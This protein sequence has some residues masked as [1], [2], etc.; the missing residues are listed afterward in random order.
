MGR[1]N[2][3][4]LDVECVRCAHREGAHDKRHGEKGSNKP[5]LENHT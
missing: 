5:M 3:A 2:E 4:H 1:S